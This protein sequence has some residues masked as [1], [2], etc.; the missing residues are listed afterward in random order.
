MP[1]S[2][3][4]N[5]FPA[6]RLCVKKIMT[7]LAALLG[8]LAS[9]SSIG[10]VRSCKIST[11]NTIRWFIT[12]ESSM[13]SLGCLRSIM[14][15]NLV[16]IYFDTP[17]HPILPINTKMGVW[18]SEALLLST[19]ASLKYNSKVYEGS[20]EAQQVYFKNGQ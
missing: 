5:P 10:M 17:K 6:R 12:T 4:I 2:R 16:I 9:I 20:Q 1:W 15:H 11:L 18:A 7:A 14:T 3:L 8:C 13:I 19:S